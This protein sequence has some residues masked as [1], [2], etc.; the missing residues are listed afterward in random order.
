MKPIVILFVIASTPALFPAVSA[1]EE[2]ET[3]WMPAAPEGLPSDFDWIR[4]PSDEWLKG[5]II[6][7]YDGEL[8]FDS[9]ELDDLT[10]DFDDIKE[11]RTSRVVQVGFEKRDPAIGRM[12][13]DSNTVRIIGEA[14]EVTFRSVGD[15]DHHRR[16]AEGDQLLVGL[17][18]RRRQYS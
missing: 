6:S 15:P 8:E 5:E 16:H 11:I 12:H 14:G 9:D 10:F 13:M 2:E 18:D 3:P 4:L 7:M 17:C 1:A